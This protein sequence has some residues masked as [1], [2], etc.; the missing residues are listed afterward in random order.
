[1]I[2]FSG[3]VV[4][5][6]INHEL[7]VADAVAWSAAFVGQRQGHERHDLDEERGF[8]EG[9]PWNDNLPCNCGGSH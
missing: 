5:L 4:S 8:F 6:A 2:P 7:Q 3:H 1:V 9:L